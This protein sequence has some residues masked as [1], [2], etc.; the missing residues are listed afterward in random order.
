MAKETLEIQ[1]FIAAAA[2]KANGVRILGAVPGRRVTIQFDNADGEAERLLD[3]HL[4]GGLQV[5]SAEFA[6]ALSEVK[7]IIFAR[8]NGF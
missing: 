2:L 1:E 7:S 6:L 3:R 5:N 8:K 4:N